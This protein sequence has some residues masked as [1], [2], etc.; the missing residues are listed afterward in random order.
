MAYHDERAD[1]V[2]EIATLRRQQLECE[3]D[4]TYL[5]WT[6]KA[7]LVRERRSN[8]ISMLVASLDDID[9][10]MPSSGFQAQ[11]G[12][13]GASRAVT[14]GDTPPSDSF[15]PRNLFSVDSRLH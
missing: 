13:T 8:R 10:S 1:V 15:H 7:S 2:A 4:A 5:G 3:I 12:R 14:G 11:P 9:R 6:L